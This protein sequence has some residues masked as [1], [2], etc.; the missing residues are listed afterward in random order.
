MID[1]VEAKL[2]ENFNGY[3]A[4]EKIP[5]LK[6]VKEMAV[7]YMLEDSTGYIEN[8]IEK[9]QNR[10]QEDIEKVAVELQEIF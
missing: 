2:R 8:L 3:I 1:E 10:A 4:A 6:E 5:E 7:N 9:M